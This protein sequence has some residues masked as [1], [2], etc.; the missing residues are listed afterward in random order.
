MPIE[1]AVDTAIEKCIRND[2]LADF[3]KKN[4]AE[5]KNMSIFE[6]DEEEYTRLTLAEGREQGRAEGR[7]EGREEGREEGRISAL[8]QSIQGLIETT[9]M[10]VDQAMDAIKVSESDRAA[11][12]SL[13]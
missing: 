4:K 11:M 13:L 6:Y 8:I 3:L 9:G 1:Q 2:I 7:A 10:T 5:A 12:E